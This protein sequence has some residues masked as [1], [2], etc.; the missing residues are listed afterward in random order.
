MDDED[1]KDLT[2]A[3]VRELLAGAERQVRAMSSPHR[4]IAF[5]DVR[6]DDLI[7]GHPEGSGV[8]V[9]VKDVRITGNNVVVKTTAW[10]AYG[11]RRQ[12]IAVRRASWDK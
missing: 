9:R 7:S 1:T 6:P 5:E 11:H 3:E 8:W 12:G 2:E 10:T 4:S